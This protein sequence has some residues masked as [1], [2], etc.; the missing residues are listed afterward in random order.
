MRF[1]IAGLGPAH[2]GIVDHGLHTGWRNE[3]VTA[4]IKGRP[5]GAVLC[6][7]SLRP[8]AAASE[9]AAAARARYERL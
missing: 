4:N 6:V 3:A 7:R 2:A 9:E 5:D 8:L 1:A